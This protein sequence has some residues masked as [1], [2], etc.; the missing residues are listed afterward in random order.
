[1][2]TFEGHILTEAVQVVDTVETAQDYVAGDFVLE[3]SE[4]GP[5]VGGSQVRIDGTIY[6]YDESLLTTDEAVDFSTVTL[7]T[8]LVADAPTGT[9]LESWNPNKGDV[10]S[11]W[12]VQVAPDAEPESNGHTATLHD[13]LI[14]TSSA[15]KP[16][17][18]GDSVTVEV[19]SDSSWLVVNKV[20]ATP[21]IDPG[22]FRTG[23]IQAD[24]Q[25]TV[26]DPDGKRVVID[27]SP[28]IEAYDATNTQTVQINGDANFMQ[29]SIAT[30]KP[31]EGRVA[32]GRGEFSDQETNEVRIE[33]G[34]A[35]E[36]G[37][38]KLLAGAFDAGGHRGIT[39]LRGQ[40]WSGAPGEA[41]VV[42]LLTGTDDGLAGSEVNITADKINLSAPVEVGGNLVATMGNGSVG[43]GTFRD[44]VDARVVAV[45]GGSPTASSV[46]NTPA[47]NISATNV[48]A[49]LNEL[50]TEKAPLAS[51]AFTGNPTAPTQTAGNNSTRVATTA[52]V[53]TADALKAPLASPTFTGTVSGITKSMVGLGSVDNTADTAKPVSTAQQTALNLKADLASPAL[54]GNPTAPTQTAGN[55]STRIATTAYTDTGLA[56][57]A[58][59]ASPTFTGTPAAPTP[60]AADNTT[61]LATTAFVQGEISAKAPLASPT[62]T[63]D[64]KAPTPSGGDTDTSIE[65]CDL[66]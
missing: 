39:Q 21:E 44:S 62:F 27:G 3:I 25:I 40:D 37:P 36:A 45:G 23:T 42:Q 15:S 55:N 10:N 34:D 52:Y 30:D 59:L 64:P 7:S 24:V 58:N 57:K 29:G 63:G 38:S 11:E 60:T 8:P 41:P 12:K 28:A 16:L 48:Q 17:F 22:Y 6:D 43:T 53:D 61:K 14:P 2:E 54:T 4:I 33:S 49:A 65:S 26:G 31:G 56:L 19:Q 46:T 51:P 18:V 32:I 47:G 50:D 1:M 5:L 20:G 66:F 35:S 9:I 13:D